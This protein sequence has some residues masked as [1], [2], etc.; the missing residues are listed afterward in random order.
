MID[1]FKRTFQFLSASNTPLY[2][3]LASYI[4]IQIQSGVFKP[5]DQMIAENELCEILKVSRT[6]IRQCMNRLV[7]E[8]LLVRYRGKG[9]FIADQKIRRNINYMYNFTENIRNAG[10]VPSS[11]VLQKE[12]GPADQIIAEKLCLP[13]GNAFV[14]FLSR[15][16]CANDE[17][18][19][20]EKTYIPYYLC[21]GIEAADFSHASLYDT[22]SSRY[23]LN[24]SRA[25]ETIE[26][27]IISGDNEKKLKCKGRVPGYKIQRI[28]YLESN[29][30]FEY[31][32]SVTR[33]DKCV[34][35]LDLYK[36]TNSIKH[37]VDFERKLQI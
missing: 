18:I 13:P 33:S 25:V 8:G 10:A 20:L 24:L 21:E 27:V 5:G 32:T 26:A 16:R 29:T 34:F 7:D 22:L 15:L 4:K 23:S 37:N 11:V 28:S 35:R 19:L 17:P 1:Y 30:V 3:Q 6:T 31:T 14:F 2:A 36:N 9:S 12:V